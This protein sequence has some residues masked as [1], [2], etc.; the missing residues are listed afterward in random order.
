MRFVFFCF[1]GIEHG[2]LTQFWKVDAWTLAELADNQL[3]Q[4]QDIHF[5]L[6]P[7]LDEHQNIQVSGNSPAVFLFGS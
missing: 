2:F 3:T 4:L 1:S 5:E 7:K 6:F